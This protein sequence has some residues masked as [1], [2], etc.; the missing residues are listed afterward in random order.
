MEGSSIVTHFQNESPSD[1]GRKSFSRQRWDARSSVRSRPEKS[2][3]FLL[4]G[5]FFPPEKQPILLA[6]E[7]SARG[8]AVKQEILL[9]SFFKYLHDIIHLEIHL[10]AAACHHVI[11]GQLP[12]VYPH[13]VKLDAY[14]ILI[15]EYYHVYLAQHLMMQL[16]GHF[17]SRRKVTFPRSDSWNAV[18]QVRAALPEE[19][20]AVFEILAVSIFETTLVRE[21]VEFFDSRDVH[22]SIRYYV[23]D[24]MNDESRHFGY[25]FDLLEYTWANIPENYQN[26]I[27]QHLARFIKLYLHVDSD[28]TFNRDLLADIL[29][30][31]QQSEQIVADIYNGF[32]ITPDIPIVKNV[33]GVLERT[34]ILAHQAVRNGFRALG[35]DL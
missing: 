28:R 17:P 20:H 11:Y 21:L 23:N 25:F 5:Y 12:V 35:W 19:M 15:D 2:I 33:L 31:E 27:G 18:V 30:D 22:P 9:Q 14:T 26:E 8:E 34:G 13:S 32:D 7:V 24:H 1:K 6:S 4:P 3:D 10:I 16:D 29:S